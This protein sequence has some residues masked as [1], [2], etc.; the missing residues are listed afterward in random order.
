MKKTEFEI[1][2]EFTEKLGLKNQTDGTLYIYKNDKRHSA[3]KP[4]GYYFLD[5]TT[6]ILD[7][8]AEGVSFTGQLEDYMKQEANPNFIGFKYNGRIFECY[9]A[10]K[11]KPNEIEIKHASYYVEKY[12]PNKITNPEL[13]AEN[14]KTLANAFRN[15]GINKQYNVPFIGAVMLCLKY[16]Q[17]LILDISTNSLLQS[18]KTGI[19]KI[20]EDEPKTKKEKKDFL[21]KI[22]E[23]DSLKR[24]KLNDLNEII[25]N[26]SNTYNFINVSEQSGQDTMNNFLKVFR[27]W[28]SADSQ[29]KGEVFTPDHIAQ[30]MI[31]LIDLSIDDVVLDPTC[32]SGTFLINSMFYLTNLANNDEKKDY[33]KLHQLIGIEL[34]PF[35]ATLAGINMLLHGDGSSQIYKEN[36]FSKLP[37]IKGLYNKVLMNPPFSQKTPELDFV[38]I[39]LDNCKENG[40]LAVVLPLTVINEIKNHK[41]LK[42]HTLTKIV[43]LSRQ[44]FLPFAAVWTGIAVFDTHKP[45]DI[46]YEIQSYNYENDGYELHRGKNGRFKVK[47]IPFDFNKYEITKIKNHSLFYFEQKKEKINF[48]SIVRNYFG[49]LITNGIKNELLININDNV[50]DLDNSEWKEYKLSELFKNLSSGKEPN[51]KDELSGTILIAAKKV[52]EAIKGRKSN[53]KKIF[54]A[55]ESNALLTVVSQGDGGS[56]LTFAKSYD[57]CAASTIK[58]L[59]P[60]NFKMNIYLALFISTCCSIEWFKKYGHGASWRFDNEVVRLPSNKNGSPDFEFMENYIKSIC[61]L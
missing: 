18:I 7:A 47:E 46:N 59:K 25:S 9:V 58:I 39:A 35:N 52:N 14:A 34:D 44:L 5:G 2:N 23:D 30:L 8:K 29:E 51:T 26:I 56:G 60:I 38:E 33:I 57:F 22:F 24:A 40:K 15:S 27:K 43:K 21:K 13:V 19:E 53:P 16:K 49:S 61:S 1:V 12:F 50:G 4:D 42:K 28:N 48:T 6:F 32:G 55:T 54:N 36:C 3:K 31:K 20:I 11:L 17:E 45:H 10:G 41:L 37:T